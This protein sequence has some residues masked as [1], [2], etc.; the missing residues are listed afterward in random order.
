MYASASGTNDVV[1][2]STAT[3]S[4][5]SRAPTG[6]YPDGIAYDSADHKIYVSNEHDHLETV[7]DARTGKHLGTVDVGGNAG[8]T[9]YDPTTGQILVNVQNTGRIAVIDPTTERCVDSIAVTGCDSNHGLYIEPVAR[10]AF[11]A[12]EGNAMLLAIDLTTKRTVQRLTVGATPDV[13]AYDPGIH[14]LYVASESGT[15]AV[16]DLKARRL[17]NLG[18]AVL[19]PSAHTVAVDSTTHRVFIPLE[20]VDGHPV[21]RV[22]EP[23]GP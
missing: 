16:F 23:S 3:L 8:N 20:N 19:A 5:A 1:G 7:I 12:C 21:L 6:Q 10:L 18:Q 14:R 9:A 13:I 17:Q 22:L 15:V 4:V 2:I 11:V